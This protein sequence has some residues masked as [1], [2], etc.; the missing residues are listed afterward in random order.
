MGGCGST[1][2]EAM[3]RRRRHQKLEVIFGYITSSRQNK[4]ERNVTW[5]LIAEL[6]KSQRQEAGSGRWQTA[7][8][9]Q[10]GAEPW[11]MRRLGRLMGRG[12]CAG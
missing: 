9:N 5:A 2:I 4:E 11:R 3:G 1:L 6:F 8:L 10:G 7:Y 12:A